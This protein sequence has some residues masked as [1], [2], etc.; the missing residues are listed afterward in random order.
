MRRI[1]LCS[2]LCVSH[3]AFADPNDA[4]HRAD[5]ARTRWLN[6]QAATVAGRRDAR[7]WDSLSAYRA[8]RARYARRL[9]DWR[10]R[11]SECKA[12]YYRACD[13]R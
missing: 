11:V 2:L 5:R 1:L 13:D 12:G 8:A 7:N 3:P 6:S 4:A 9:A 10:Q